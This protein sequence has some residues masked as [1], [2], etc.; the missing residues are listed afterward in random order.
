[1]ITIMHKNLKGNTQEKKLIVD[2]TDLK[3]VQVSILTKGNKKLQES[4][5][6]SNS[7]LLIGTFSR[8]GEGSK[9]LLKLD[10]YPVEETFG[11]EPLCHHC[12]D[13]KSYCYNRR[14]FWRTNVLNSRIS[15]TLITQDTS[16]FSSSLTVALS[17]FQKLAKKKGKQPVVRIHVEGDLSTEAYL[18]AW[19]SNIAQFDDIQ[20]YTYTKCYR[21]MLQ[22]KHHVMML[23]NLNVMISDN[24][25]LSASE[26]ALIH[27]LR[28]FGFKTY[29]CTNDV[30]G[31]LKEN[32]N[33]IECN[34]DN[35]HSCKNCIYGKQDVACKIR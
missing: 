16:L 5:D 4:E 18:L 25:S 11:D 8:L 31:M 32:S 1:M 3:S 26:K 23:D 21:L 27:D 12:D 13:C 2:Y 34:G 28:R 7:D 33:A 19:L 24:D 17:N 22:Y 29:Y 35:C 6:A 14:N 20:F 10:G 30:V 15:N 9:Q